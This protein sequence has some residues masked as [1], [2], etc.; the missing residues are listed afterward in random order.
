M[1][2]QLADGMGT[3]VDLI[4]KKPDLV[5]K[6]VRALAQADAKARANPD[7]AAKILAKRLKMPNHGKELAEA[8]IAAMPD[9]VTPAPQLYADDAA[10]ISS[11]A[12]KPVTTAQVKATWDTRF[13]V[14]IDREMAK[15]K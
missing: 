10:F 8:L 15:A 12:K 5:R 11:N 13:A 3:S 4:E 2:T 6:M 7:W 14:E 9:G 1:P